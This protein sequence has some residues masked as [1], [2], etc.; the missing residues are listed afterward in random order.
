[1]GKIKD[2]LVR[3]EETQTWEPNV[4]ESVV[5]KINNNSRQS[6]P[7][8]SS[9][10]FQIKMLLRRRTAPGEVRHIISE[11]WG[12]TKLVNEIIDREFKDSLKSKK[13]CN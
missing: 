13:Q 8:E 3:E 1:M 10:A 5:R 7:Y 6:H 11:K 2:Q 12:H 9:I 4:P